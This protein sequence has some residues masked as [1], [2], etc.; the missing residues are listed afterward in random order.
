[1]AHTLAGQHPADQVRLLYP[2]NFNHEQSAGSIQDVVGQVD[3]S[4]RYPTFQPLFS[5]VETIS[6]FHTGLYG[7]RKTI[8]YAALLPIQ[9]LREQRS[10][11]LPTNMSRYYVS[12][13]KM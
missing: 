2:Q 7:C 9:Y 11:I 1:M 10:A 13:R 12:T 6:Y 5:P 3:T 8:R 4:V